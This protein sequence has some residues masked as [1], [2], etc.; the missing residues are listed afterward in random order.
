MKIIVPRQGDLPCLILFKE[1]ISMD[2]Y[3]PNEWNAEFVSENKDFCFSQLLDIN[4]QV[5][6][7]LKK[8]D[9]EA[10]VAGIDRMLNGAIT[11]QNSGVADMKPFLSTN[12]FAQGTIIVCGLNDAPEMKRRETAIAAFSD[13]RDFAEPDMTESSQDVIIKL[14][15]GQKMNSI[16]KEICPD[17]PADLI[18]L[19][20]K[21]RKTPDSSSAPDKTKSSVS[22]SPSG[23]AQPQNNAAYNA[24]PP[25][26]SK[27]GIIVLVLIIGI[28]IGGAVGGGL[29]YANS[30]G[31]FSSRQSNNYQSYYQS[32][33]DEAETFKTTKVSLRYFDLEIPEYWGDKYYV[34]ESEEEHSDIDY[35]VSFYDK[36]SYVKIGDSNRNAVILS[37]RVSESK[38]DIIGEITLDKT[39]YISLEDNGYLYEDATYSDYFT[40]MYKSVPSIIK[41]I[42]SNENSIELYNYENIT[43]IRTL[44]DLE[45]ISLADKV[46]EGQT[47]LCWLFANDYMIDKQDYVLYSQVNSGYDGYFDDEKLPSAYGIKTVD[48]L[49]A[50]LSNYYTDSYIQSHFLNSDSDRWETGDWYEY[51]G[52][53][54]FSSIWESGW[55]G[56]SKEHYNIEYTSDSTLVLHTTVGIYD[57]EDEYTSTH[58]D[59]TLDEH[60][61]FVLEDGRLKLDKYVY[62]MPED[63]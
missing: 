57:Y 34:E 62:D 26:K 53:I 56:I 39:Y 1:G 55:E 47:K 13:A 27:S 4:S 37:I 35:F 15:S 5:V 16:A 60:F 49:K 20:S 21:L 58:F 23:N 8:G 19:M 18:N 59:G 7:C 51:E 25:A 52:N 38:Y 2:K 30:K 32:T 46:N 11:I 29:F 6:D 22:A 42:S 17:F 31:M 61:Y 44:S 9:Y 54:Y 43:D 63:Y 36:D 45:I 24:Q 12:S 3:D 48:D 40:A 41:T 14:E 10:A 50:Y 28:L 33:Q